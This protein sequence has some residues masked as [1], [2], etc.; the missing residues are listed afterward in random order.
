[1][2]R[3]YKDRPYRLF[4]K[5]AAENGY[6]RILWITPFEV[7][8]TWY[9]D[10]DGYLYSRHN[11]RIHVPLKHYADWRWVEDDWLTDYGNE[12]RIKQLLKQA[13]DTANNG[14]MDDDWDNP[15]VYQRRRSWH[16]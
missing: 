6:W 7:D 1:M 2:S 12:H 10:T 9:A 16:L 15:L 11:Q 8:D 3:T 5:K 13:C 14:L 4:Q